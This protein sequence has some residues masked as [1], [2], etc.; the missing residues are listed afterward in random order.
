MRA[1]NLSTQFPEQAS[2]QYVKNPPKK[3]GSAGVVQKNPSELLVARITTNIHSPLNNDRSLGVIARSIT[4]TITRTSL[5]K[6]LRLPRAGRDPSGASR[7]RSA[8]LAVHSVVDARS[9]SRGSVFASSGAA[10]GC[11]VCE[12]C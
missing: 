1:I 3:S 2:V 4:V 9:G 5:N 6:S 8:V 11:Y 12:S 7:A 10:E